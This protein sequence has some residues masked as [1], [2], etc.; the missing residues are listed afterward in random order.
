M[1]LAS[2]A[3]AAGIVASLSHPLIEHISDLLI[4]LHRR[5]LVDHR[6]PYAVMAHPRFQVRQAHPILGRRQSSNLDV[7][8]RLLL[9]GGGR[10]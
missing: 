7:L 3:L 8:L 5:V 10:A 2:L 9:S 6:G 4:G 1:P